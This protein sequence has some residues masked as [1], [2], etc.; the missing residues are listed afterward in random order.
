MKAVLEESCALLKEEFHISDVVPDL[1]QCTGILTENIVMEALH[2]AKVC[3]M[4]NFI[5]VVFQE[6]NSF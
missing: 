3:Y 6:T 5:S 1:F 2:F 4:K